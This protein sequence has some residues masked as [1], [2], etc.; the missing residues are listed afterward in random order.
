MRSPAAPT[1]STPTGDG[2]EGNRRPSSAYPKDPFKLPSVHSF[3]SLAYTPAGRLKTKMLPRTM[4]NLPARRLISM[5]ALRLMLSLLDVSELG[6]R[7]FPGPVRYPGGPDSR[8]GH[9]PILIP[10]K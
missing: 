8:A 2:G 5:N 1:S 3:P 6:S 9:T 4:A 10:E 7:P